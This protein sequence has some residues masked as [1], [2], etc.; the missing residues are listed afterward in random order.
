MDFSYSQ[1]VLVSKITC[2]CTFPRTPLYISTDDSILLTAT[3]G[4][5]V[6]LK[7]CNKMTEM[8]NSVLNKILS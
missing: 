6:A 4:V 5:I 1:K 3:S 2:T 7:Y 8:C